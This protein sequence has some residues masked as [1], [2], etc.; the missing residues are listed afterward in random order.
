LGP[1]YINLGR[2]TIDKL[3]APFLEAAIFYLS[4]TVT[5]AVRQRTG[6]TYVYSVLVK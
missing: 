6:N 2:E 4:R 5:M 1:N 3:M